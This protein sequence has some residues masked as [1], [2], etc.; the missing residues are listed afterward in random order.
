MDRNNMIQ[1]F[2]FL[3]RLLQI[4]VIDGFLIAPAP[5]CR[6]NDI[7]RSTFDPGD[8]TDARGINYPRGRKTSHLFMDLWE[9]MEIEEDDEPYWYLLNCIAGLEMDLLRQ[10]QQASESLPAE[11]VIKFVVP[12]MVKT[13]SHGASRMVRETKVK[14]QGY[15]FAKLRLTKETYET[16][17]KIDLCRSWMGTINMKGYKKLPP[18]P[19]PLGEEEIENFDLENPKWENDEH[20]EASDN[21]QGIIVD[22]YEND[23]KEMEEEEAIEVEVKTVYKSLKVEDMIKVTAKNKFSGE[24]G[25]VKRLKEGK[26][27]IRFFTYGQTFDEWLDP[28]DVRKLTDEEILKGLGGPSAPITQRDLDGDRDDRGNKREPRGDERNTVGA[29]GGVRGR[30]RRQDRTERGFRRD[31]ISSKKERENWNW[32][33]ENEKRSEGGGYDDGDDVEF[34]AGSRS[35]SRRGNDRGNF[36][37]ESDVDSQWGRTKKDRQSEEEDDWSSFVSQTSSNDKNKPRNAPSKEETDDF[38]AS[39]MT[40]LSKDDGGQGRNRPSEVQQNDHSSPDNDD[41]FFASLMSEIEDKPSSRSSQTASTMEANT[42]DDDDDFFAS[43]EKGIRGSDR[44]SKKSV[45]SNPISSEEDD[46]F[47]SLEEELASDLGESKNDRP[48]M[49]TKFE[50]SS[51]IDQASEDDFFSSLEAELRSDLDTVDVEVNDTT[52]I[53]A[54]DKRHSSSKR[55]PTDASQNSDRF[56]ASSLKKRTVAELKGILRDRGLK[57]SGRKA[58]LIDRITS[59]V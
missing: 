6:T 41:D 57:V 8:P 45:D 17:K 27:L 37:A 29:F 48:K 12:T 21:D 30:E 49:D 10:V 40:D 26:V 31:P 38:F 15:V 36:W 18:A 24:D 11:D 4:P 34:R 5:Q 52:K 59:A 3:L 50:T 56:D 33:K 32:Y 2:V 46:F 20:Q 1:F 22:S 47:A 54:S 9:R 25:I 44:S 51:E 28:G 53:P 7:R 55:E 58:E 43:L 42:S 39:L 23:M 13:R 16:I 14:Y 19:L 35:E